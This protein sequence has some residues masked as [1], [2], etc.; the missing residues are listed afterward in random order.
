MQQAQPVQ[1]DSYELSIRHNGSNPNHHIWNNN[2][3]L[4]LN[5]SEVSRRFKRRNRVSLGL[6]PDQIAEARKLRDQ[7]FR[8]RLPAA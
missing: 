5:Y 1:D 6:K 4:F 7:F 8:T 3:T 2:G